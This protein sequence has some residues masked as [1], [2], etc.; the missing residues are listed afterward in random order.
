DRTDR[1]RRALARTEADDQ[2]VVVVVDQLGR[3]GQQPAQLRERG[4]RDRAHLRRV[5]REEPIELPRR[6]RR[7]Y[8]FSTA[9]VPPAISLSCPFG[10]SDHV[11]FADRSSSVA[12][13][14]TSALGSSGKS[15]FAVSLLPSMATLLRSAV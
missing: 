13:T 7:G 14:T 12:A 5:L 15:Y 4:L 9:H 8:F 1:L 11:P 3:A 10:R 2:R 6:G